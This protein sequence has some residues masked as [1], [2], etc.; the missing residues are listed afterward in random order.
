MKHGLL[1]LLSIL[2]LSSCD[3]TI[4]EEPFDPRLNFVGRY[5]AEE[6]SETF[7]E[8]VYYPV[9]VS[10]DDGYYSNSIYLENF[11]DLNADVYA[12]VNGDRITIPRQRIGDWLI[13]GTGYLDYGDIVMTYSVEDLSRPR[14]PVDF[15]NT[16]LYVD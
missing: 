9:R 1:I 6:Y 3:L 14:L 5:E 4:I 12:Q 8:F 11:Y 7:D 10:L 2:F 16:V 13:Q 15:C